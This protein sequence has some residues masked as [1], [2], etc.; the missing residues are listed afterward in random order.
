MPVV[1]L[2]PR[3][4]SA[5]SRW[6]QL[7]DVQREV[8]HPERG[9]LAHG[10]ELGRLEVG[11]GQAGH[12]RRAAAAKPLQRVEHGQQPAQ[13]EAEAFADDQQVGV[14]GDEGAGG[15]EVEEG[16]G[17]GRL[18]AEG[19]DVGH[20]VVAEPPLV[21]GGRGQVGVVEMGAHLRQRR[22][23]DVEPQLPLRL[24]QRQPEPAPEADAVRLAPEPLHGGRGVAGAERGTPAV[25]GHRNTRSV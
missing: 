16:P 18:V 23:R 19:V 15:A 4:R 6:Q 12:G 2:Q 8:L 7:L 1:P 17:R 25:V 20:H 10:G 13:H 24:G 21:L 14:V 22:V 3:S 5:S 9:P 11:V